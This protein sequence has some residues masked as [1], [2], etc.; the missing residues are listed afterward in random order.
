MCYLA[1]FDNFDL[2]VFPL[3]G[4]KW[5]KVFP[6]HFSDAPVY[7]SV[8]KTTKWE[9]TPFSHYLRGFFQVALFPSPFLVTQFPAILQTVETQLT[10]S[11][12]AQLVV[13]LQS[14]IKNWQRRRA[15]PPR[16]QYHLLG[17]VGVAL[18]E[19]SP[20][21][22]PCVRIPAWTLRQSKDWH[23]LRVKQFFFFHFHDYWHC[24]LSF[25]SSKFWM[26]THIWK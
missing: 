8:W 25:K 15:A 9:S 24:R 14:T 18:Q 22:G 1:N 11:W 19:I 17:L 4:V 6:W 21:P 20:P 26:N 5:S 10:V 12:P 3:K 16:G 13:K 2:R 23:V 7:W